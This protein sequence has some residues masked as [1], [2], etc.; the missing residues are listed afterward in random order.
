MTD[1]PASPAPDRDLRPRT[2]RS[3]EDIAAAGLVA[4]EKVAAIAQVAGRY[5]V[6]ITPTLAHLID[7]TDAADP[8]ARQFVPDLRE[9]EAR[10]TELADP[11]GDDSHSPTRGIVHRYPDR[12]LLTP[13]LH[14]PVYCRFCFRREKVGGD[15]AVLSNEDLERAV[16]YIRDHADIWEVV[17]T[18]GDPLMLP[19]ARLGDLLARLAAIDHVAVIRIH[20]RIPISDPGRIDE[21]MLAALRLDKALWLAVHCNHAREIGADA[22]GALGRLSRAGIPLL[23]QTVLLKGVNDEPAVMEALM[24]ALVAHRV[25]PYYLHHLDLAPGTDHF[26]TSIA[27]GQDLMRQLHG[28]VSGLCQPHYVLDIPGGYGK[29]PIGPVYLADGAVEDWQGQSHR[30]PPAG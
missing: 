28:R 19:P 30:Y 3:G 21:A 18:G 24:R 29:A 11:I 12:V 15:L 27:R 13:I 20:S 10:P 8:I 6:A 1:V 4:A 7:P 23:G 16:A 17:L 22:A 14:C 26:R 25:K 5:A 9:L 2:L